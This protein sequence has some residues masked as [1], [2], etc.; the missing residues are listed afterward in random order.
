M[1]HVGTRLGEE[2][3]LSRDDWKTARLPVEDP[4]GN[5]A[6][7]TTAGSPEIEGMRL[8]MEPQEYPLKFRTIALSLPT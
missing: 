4:P 2:E 3:A 7:L 5:L 1:A 6:T 8:Q